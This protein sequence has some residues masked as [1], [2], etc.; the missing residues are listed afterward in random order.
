MF[1]GSEIFLG[2]SINGQ[3]SRPLQ[4]ISYV[5][6][7]WWSRNSGKLAGYGQQDFPKSIA[8]GFLDSNCNKVSGSKGWSSYRDL[9][10]G[11]WV[12]IVDIDGVNYN[13]R[14]YATM[15][16][17]SCARAIMTGTGSSEGDMVIDVFDRYGNRTQCEL[18]FAVLAP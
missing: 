4:I 16:T 8:Q 6:Y 9:V 10:A 12:C 15:V 3:E 7:A 18:S 1:S 5:P 14:N 11:A 13:H 2:V 17:P